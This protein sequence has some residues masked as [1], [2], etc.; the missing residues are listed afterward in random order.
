MRVDGDRR[1]FA[2]GDVAGA[3]HEGAELPMMS[4]PA[5]QQGRYVADYIL[6]HL[7]DGAGDP[8]KL[9]PFS[10]TDKGAM[11]TIGRNAAVCAVGDLQLTGFLGWVGWLVVHIYY[12]IGFRN[13][14]VV[15]WAWCWNYIWYDRP[16][17][18]ITRARLAAATRGP[19]PDRCSGQSGAATR[20]PWP[21]R[22][23]PTA[24]PAD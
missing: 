24:S 23:G 20:G 11:A 3:Q 18:I 2:I 12:L 16:V 1:L 13:R 21:D 15:L 19:R 17:R 4:P 9:P 8:E 5:M 6:H 7:A 10:Y 14:L 22:R